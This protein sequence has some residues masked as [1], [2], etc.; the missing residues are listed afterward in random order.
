MRLNI[1]Q[2]KPA[3]VPTPQAQNEPHKEIEEYTVAT[4][5]P[6]KIPMT[7]ELLRRQR[8]EEILEKYCKPTIKTGIM[9]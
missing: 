1:F 9:L 8:E 4:F 3:P 5:V 7:S 2:K 6:R